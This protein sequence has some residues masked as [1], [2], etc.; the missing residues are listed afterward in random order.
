MKQ[1]PF[2]VEATYQESSASTP[3]FFVLFPGVDPTPLVENLGKQFDVILMCETL[4]NLDYYEE[5]IECIRRHAHENTK[6]LIEDALAEPM[7]CA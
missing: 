3:I 6:V 1:P 5:L 2:D 7:C 4:Y